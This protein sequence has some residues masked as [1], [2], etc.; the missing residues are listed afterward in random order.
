V[1]PAGAVA[2]T[3]EDLRAF[4]EDRLARF[5]LPTRLL[6]LDALPRSTTEKISRARIREI[7]QKRLAEAAPPAGAGTER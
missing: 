1:V 7:Y 5:K 6:V 3:L 2:P 4:A